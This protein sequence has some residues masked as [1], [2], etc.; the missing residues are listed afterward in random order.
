MRH[1]LLDTNHIR[2]AVK[3]GSS[4]QER[5]REARRKGSRVGVCVP[6]ICEFEIGLQQAR[7]PAAYRKRIER[8]FSRFRIWPLDWDTARVYGTIA[9]LLRSRGKVL[10][11]VDMMQA[12]LA[13]QMKLTLVT[14]DRDFEALPEVRT[15][16]WLQL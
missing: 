1:Y 14:G 6:V 16:N 8:L 2:H 12:A 13:I 15:E 10:S 3:E 9:L 4:V 5:L 7:D 11:Q